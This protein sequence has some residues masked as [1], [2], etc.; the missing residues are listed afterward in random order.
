MIRIHLFTLAILFVVGTAQAQY[1]Y[2][3]VDV[4]PNSMHHGNSV[5]PSYF[6]GKVILHYFGS[7]TWG[8]C[9]TRFGELNDIYE[10]LSDQ[11][12]NIELVGISKSSSSIALSNWT[13]Q[14]SASICIDEAPYQVWS[15]WAATQR[16]LFITDLNGAVVYQQNITSGIPTNIY[17]TILNYLSLDTELFPNKISLKQNYPNPF[18]PLTFIHYDLPEDE[19]INIAVYDMNGR[20]VKTLVSGLQTAGY[21]SIRWNATND[22]NV[23][24]SAGLYLYSIQAGEFSYTKKMLLLK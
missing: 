7:F 11:G 20:L 5:G 12:H 14:G 6:E 17:D 22:R 24:V 8:T 9:T 19:I 13:A 16:D 1:S 10:T 3:L 21:K 18:N 4:N 23:S 15:N 2:S